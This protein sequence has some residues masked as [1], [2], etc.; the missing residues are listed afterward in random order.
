MGVK[1]DECV[2][3]KSDE[4]Q[5]TEVGVVL[6]VECPMHQKYVPVKGNCVNL[7]L[8]EDGVRTDSDVRLHGDPIGFFYSIR[9]NCK[10]ARKYILTSGDL[11]GIAC[12]YKQD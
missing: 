2:E 5:L 3:V 12:A 9:S 6:C 4:L 8:I 10:Y 1:L 11:T 7:K